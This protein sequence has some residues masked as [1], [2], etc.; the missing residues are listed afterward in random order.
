MDAVARILEDARITQLYG[1]KLSDTYAFSAT[2]SSIGERP[3]RRGR[4]KQRT[5]CLTNI[6]ILRVYGFTRV[7]GGSSS[8]LPLPGVYKFDMIKTL[9]KIRPDTRICNG[10]LRIV[11]GE[12]GFAGFS[13]ITIDK[14]FQ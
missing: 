13:S 11:Y 9:A 8:T 4:G 2:V 3:R 12:A 7:S 14:T 10:W 5:V 1:E 6:Q